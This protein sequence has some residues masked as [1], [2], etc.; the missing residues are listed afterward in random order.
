MNLHDC[1]NAIGL[2]ER[3]ACDLTG[4]SGRVARY[5]STRLDD[6]PLRPRLRELTAE[7][8]RF[9][10]WRLG[11]MLAREGIVP[12]DKRLLWI[13]REEGLRVRRRNGRKGGAGNARADDFSRE[14]AGLIADTSICGARVARELAAYSCAA[15]F[16]GSTS[17]CKCS[18]PQPQC[19]MAKQAP[20]SRERLLLETGTPMASAQTDLRPAPGF[21]TGPMCGHQEQQPSLGTSPRDRL[22]ELQQ[23]G[24]K[25]I[26]H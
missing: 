8:C 1:V 6:A 10:C 26:G 2:S 5:C 22:T 24:G 12:N 13:Y 4:I 21:R 7:R 25:R 14:C 16:Q 11:Q 3:L 19:S 15:T 23:Q 20:I 18:G 17:A 9:G